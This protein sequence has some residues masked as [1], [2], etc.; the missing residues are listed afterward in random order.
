MLFTNFAGMSVLLVGSRTS[1]ETSCAFQLAARAR[2][3]AVAKRVNAPKLLK[4][5]RRPYHGRR[6][7]VQPPLKEKVNERPAGHGD[8]DRNQRMCQHHL[9]VG[10]MTPLRAVLRRA[11]PGPEG[12]N[13]WARFTVLMLYLSPL[14]IPLVFGVP[15]AE[16]LAQLD[17][18]ALAQ[19]VLSSALFGAFA[20]LGGIGLRMAT[21][22]TPPRA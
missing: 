20:A 10:L 4:R 6:R 7:R 17:A 2:I 8:R 14:L 5:A 1:T 15:Y 13:F 19:R 21:L 18:G 12:E 11:C 16:A 3:H 9:V 22:R